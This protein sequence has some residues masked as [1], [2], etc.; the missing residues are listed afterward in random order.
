M[1]QLLAFWNRTKGLHLVSFTTCERCIAAIGLDG[2]NRKRRSP[3]A[4][5]LC[6]SLLTYDSAT[7]MFCQTSGVCVNPA[8]VAKRVALSPLFPI[9]GAAPPG[10]EW[11]L[12]V[13]FHD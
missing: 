6:D 1:P 11:E 2:Q 9:V 12:N 3:N 10:I 5:F 13:G 4:A 8:R 7:S